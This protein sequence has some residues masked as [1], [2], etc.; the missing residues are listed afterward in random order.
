MAYR[1]GS[2]AEPSTT[3]DSRLYQQGTM[4]G[5]SQ[6][7]APSASSDA[8]AEQSEYS[9]FVD[10]QKASKRSPTYP[11]VAHGP[12]EPHIHKSSRKIGSLFSVR[13]KR[14]VE[15]GHNCTGPY[16]IRHASTFDTYKS[17]SFEDTAVWDEKAILSLGM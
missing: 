1:R 9:D 12:S 6:T 13:P 5:D 11:F 10:F 3:L 2:E 8:W 15:I 16:G 7:R 4:V 17:A 14:Q